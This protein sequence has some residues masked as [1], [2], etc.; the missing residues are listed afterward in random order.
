MD[1]K[2]ANSISYLGAGFLRAIEAMGPWPDGQ[3][4][5]GSLLLDAEGN[6]YGTTAGDIQTGEDGLFPF[7]RGRRWGSSYRSGDGSLV[8]LPAECGYMTDHQCRSG[9]CQP[10]LNTERNGIIS[11]HEKAPVPDSLL[12][13]FD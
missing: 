10:G 8:V 7:S 12:F 11:C 2:T 6:V 4:P 1:P 13:V 5:F 3:V 9:G